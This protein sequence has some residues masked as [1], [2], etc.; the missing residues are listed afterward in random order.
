MEAIHKV[1]GQQAEFI[2]LDGSLDAIQH[3]VGGYFRPV[4]LF[5][6]LVLL[7]NDDGN[8][9]GMEPNFPVQGLG[10]I[11]GPVLFVR[12]EKENYVSVVRE[13][14]KTLTETIGFLEM[15]LPVDG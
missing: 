2:V 5:D 14:M 1:P 8:I 10:M 7:C 15:G 3:Y 12:E 9:L 6:G 13:D 11:V 4:T